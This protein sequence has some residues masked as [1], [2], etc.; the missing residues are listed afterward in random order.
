MRRHSKI[1]T[2]FLILTIFMTLGLTGCGQKEATVIPVTEPTIEVTAD[3][4]LIAYLVEKFD[5]EYYN[6]AE[7]ETMV[8]TE[9]ADFVKAGA[10]VTED[11]VEQ[12][13]VESVAMAEDGSKKVVV[14]L[15]FANSQ[16]YSDYFDMQAF[17]GT[18]AEAM[19]AGYGL[20]AA[21]TSVEDG[22]VFTKEQADK[23]S[24]RHVL[25]I[26]D[27][28]IVRCPTKV[29]YL[30]TNTTLTKEGFVDCT[31]DEGLKLVIMK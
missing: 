23:N 6:L 17:Y 4:Q 16:I 22:D 31:Q 9:I 19:Q 21:L 7:L 30:G 11:G 27:S 18:V 13:S 25:I 24:K 1:L 2:A 8:R 3:G 12:A 20:S 5:K 15:R 10:Y 26:E 29:L 14:A 28:V